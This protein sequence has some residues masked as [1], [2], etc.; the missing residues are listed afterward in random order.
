MALI[1]RN[2]PILHTEPSLPKMKRFQN[3][4][5]RDLP[6]KV[7]EYIKFLNDLNIGDNTQILET[8]SIY[9]KEFCKAFSPDLMSYG[10]ITLV[11]SLDSQ[12]MRAVPANH[13]GITYIWP[14]WPELISSMDKGFAIFL[15]HRLA[16]VHYDMLRD[17]VNH[18]LCHAKLWL[19]NC[20]EKE[21]H[22]PE[23]LRTC[24]TVAKY[25]KSIGNP[26]DFK[27]KTLNLLIDG[28]GQY[29]SLPKDKRKY[30]KF[31]ENKC[32]NKKRK[33]QK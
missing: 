33:S 14:T 5:E 18:E 12:L 20:Q 29:K 22:S 17:T 8:I 21:E 3:L 32:N 6:R 31:K 19:E 10:S 15:D 4:K 9:V 26:L 1:S 23:F 11:N 27:I 16:T 7:L 24:D 28:T 13:Y 30:N 25:F 2:K